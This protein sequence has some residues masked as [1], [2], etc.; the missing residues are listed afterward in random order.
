MAILSRMLIERDYDKDVSSSY[1]ILGTRVQLGHVSFNIASKVTAKGYAGLTYFSTD[2]GDL[3]HNC[4]F[5]DPVCAR[6]AMGMMIEGLRFEEGSVIVGS[7]P[8]SWMKKA[9]DLF[10]D[11]VCRPSKGDIGEV[12]CALYLLFCGDKIRYA[13]DK[14]LKQFSVPLDIWIS[15]LLNPKQEVTDIAINQRPVASVSCV[16]V[17]RNYLRHSLKQIMPLL[18][19]W[20]KS[21]R[22]M[23]SYSNCQG[24]DLIVPVRYQKRAAIPNEENE[25]QYD[26][27]P[28]LVSIK[29]WLDV[30][31]T[32][33]SEWKEAMKAVL[34]SEDIK[35]GFCML[36]LVGLVKV[37]N[38]LE[39]EYEDILH[40][41]GDGIYSFTVA[42]DSNDPF[43]ISDFLES[44][45]T[46]GGECSEIY[47]SHSEA[48]LTPPPDIVATEDLLRKKCSK[49]ASDY[50]KTMTE[51]FKTGIDEGIK[52]V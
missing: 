43:G 38:P 49:S 46:C 8:T 50:F 16:Q 20:Y 17:C 41:S 29:N 36:F 1:S 12:A 37:T 39:T 35:T 14:E 6:L 18:P 25:E 32:Y 42:V 30:S 3:A 47:A 26:Y 5:P 19:H 52:Y 15:L 11:N 7:G 48:F 40:F 31:S 28:L 10:S 4:F 9:S 21:G 24:F 33:E 22:A 13:I 27:C 51:E 45:S 2:N 44:A 34:D 23:Y